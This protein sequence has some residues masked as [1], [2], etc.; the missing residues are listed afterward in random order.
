MKSGREKYL[1]KKELRLM[2]NQEGKD[3]LV[4]QGRNGWKM[5]KKTLK[6]WE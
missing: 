6:R 2:E 4:D 3:A 1:I 5:W